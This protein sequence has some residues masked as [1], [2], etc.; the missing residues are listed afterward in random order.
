MK[1]LVTGASGAIGS[2]LVPL[3]VAAGHTVVATTTSEAKTARLREA[4]AE[5]VVLDVLDSEAV[6]AAVERTRPEV[7][8]HQATALAGNLK[9]RH[10]DKDFAVTNRLRI[11]GTDNLLAAAAEFGVRRFVAQSAMQVLYARTGGPVKTE[12]DPTDTHPTPGSE[13][14]VAAIRHL[15]TAVTSAAGIEGVVLRYG[16]FY[17][18]GTSLEAGGEQLE[19]VRKRQFPIVGGGG[20]VWS[21]TH[22][23]DGARATVAAVEGG[24]PGIYNVVDDDPAPLSEWLPVLAEAAGA[25]RPMSVPRWVGKLL[26]GGFIA[27][28]STEIRG[29]SNAKA[30]K[31]FGWVPHYASWR[32][33]FKAEL[34]R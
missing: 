32:D 26:A 18:P 14:T 30:R 20:G 29:A 7:I 21:F 12:T 25:K 8:V 23:A 6:R 33:G 5:P 34:G 13:K 9:L 3:L 27:M 22:V 10:V 2:Q 11:E 31:E 16:G 1:V 19:M 24:E 17:G 4:G 28:V 15:E